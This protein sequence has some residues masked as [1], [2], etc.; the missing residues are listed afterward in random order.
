[1]NVKIYVEGGGEGPFNPQAC[2]EGFAQFFASMLPGKIRPKIVA[3]GSR[4]EALDSFVTALS[5]PEDHQ[6]IILL[7]DAEGPVV[8]DDV[9]VHLKK[10]DGSKWTK[11]DLA[12]ADEA[13]LM[14]QCVESWF[15]ADPE[16]LKSHFG[17]NYDTT[18]LPKPVNGKDIECHDRK[19]VVNSINSG[20]H[21]IN[22]KAG[23]KKRRYEKT[24]AFEIVGL[25]DWKKVCE[26]SSHLESLR[27]RLAKLLHT[28][29]SN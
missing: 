16:V 17:S 27:R 2:R 4:T 6:V 21:K 9:W 26:A 11:P 20:F 12:G 8:D 25:L 14:V 19:M 18:K 29:K 28:K 5:N 23:K 7:V 22:S 24:D 3:C 1:M 10:R 13:Y 15:C